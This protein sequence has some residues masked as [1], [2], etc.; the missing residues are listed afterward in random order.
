M[1]RKHSYTQIS[2]AVHGSHIDARRL[3]PLSQRTIALK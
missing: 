2:S 1:N 3:S